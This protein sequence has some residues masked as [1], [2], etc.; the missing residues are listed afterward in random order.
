MTQVA[1]V[2]SNRYEIERPIAR[3]GMADVF[4]ARDQYLDRPVAVKVLFPEY[5]RDQSFVERFRREAQSAAMLNHPNIVNIYD[6]GQER[7]T[8][9][10]V[11]EYVE[12]RSLRDILRADGA[13][14]PMTV[15]RIGAE[16]A[17]ALDFAHRQGV[18][19]RD[20]KPG[21]VMITESGQVKVTDYGIAANPTDAKQGLTQ[22]GS[23]IGTATYF[24][25]EQAQ[26]Y[27]V[28]GRTDVYALG[29]V[30]YEM[31]TGQAP[32]SGDSP[33]AVAMKHVRE[34]PVP[35]S[36]LVPD[37]PPDLERIVLTA[38]SKDLATRYQSAEEMRADLIA[39]G[40]GRPVSA[41]V[42]AT[43]PGDEGAPTMAAA[44]PTGPLPPEYDEPHWEQEPR[45]WGAIVATVIGLALLA[46]VIVFALV[47]TKQDTKKTVAKVEVPD[48]IGKKYTDAQTELEAAG[49][50]VVLRFELSDSPP[51]EVVEQRPEAGLLKKKG[52]SVVLI[53][54]ARE[55]T[56]PDLTGQTEDQ[57]RA[58]L[59]KLNLGAEV[60]E[61]EAPN[62]APGTVITTNPKAGT[63]VNK[64][65][66]VK[67][68]IAKEPQTPIPDVTGKDQ[69]TA[70]NILTAA[71]FQPLFT[72]TPSNTVPAGIVISTVPPAGTKADKGTQVSVAVSI[73]PQAIPVTNH[74]GEPCGSAANALT[75]QGFNVSISGNPSGHVVAQ[76]P[77]SGSYPPGTQI[78]LSCV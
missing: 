64:G 74:T 78:S 38:M 33:V 54:S 67:V 37:I 29:I 65:T 72:P 14:P 68:V 17:S 10:I 18:V 36:Q 32:F 58:A 19:H 34:Q 15:A 50:R 35:P 27:Q 59:A 8:Y 13:L 20:I 1:D 56:V 31:L 40:R 60:V 25:P 52:A 61:F 21:N 3:G 66:T 45:K 51:D 43:I 63:K 75:A 46:G 76:N 30:M 77:N 53:V 26:G 55:V 28:D 73:G 62:I 7:G 23:V 49:F 11:M 9:F 22:T 6:Y 2:Y 12:G 16:I 48:V 71:G 47:A 44:A 70:S 42:P 39:F 24:S 5:A 57:A 4:L 69:A 41:P